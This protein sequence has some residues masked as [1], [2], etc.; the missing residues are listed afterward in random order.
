MWQTCLHHVALV[1]TER[2]SQSLQAGRR[3]YLAVGSIHDQEGMVSNVDKSGVEDEPT[4][5]KPALLL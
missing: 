4:V 1:L 2:I 3:P 5:V